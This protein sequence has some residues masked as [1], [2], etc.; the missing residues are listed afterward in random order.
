MMTSMERVILSSS[1][2]LSVYVELKSNSLQTVCLVPYG[3]AVAK[4]AL[5]SLCP[6]PW[7]PLVVAQCVSP[8]VIVPCNLAAVGCG[9]AL[10]Q[11]CGYRTLHLGSHW[12]WLSSVSTL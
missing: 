12:S 10:C 3:A 2:I 8:V 11:P 6:A 5:W 1:L 4:P 7:Q 9:S